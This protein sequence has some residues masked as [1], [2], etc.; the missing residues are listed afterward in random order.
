MSLS[1][2]IAVVMF[3][4][5]HIRVRWLHAHRDLSTFRG[6]VVHAG[7][8]SAPSEGNARRLAS[9]IHRERSRGGAMR[10]LARVADVDVD[11]NV[12]GDADD[13]PNPGG[14]VI[15]RASFGRVSRRARTLRRARAR[16]VRTKGILAFVRCVRDAYDVVLDD[17]GG[18]TIDRGDESGDAE[19]EASDTWVDRTMPA[20]VVPYAKLVRLD[21]PIGSALLAW[22][23]FWS[24]AL[25]ADRARCGRETA[26]VVRLGIFSPA[27]SG[28]HGERS[29]G[30]RPRW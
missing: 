12:D 10:A 16:F 22:P 18:E 8:P 13:V 20:S 7:A 30:S 5:D 23:C 25:A 6:A 19:P 14:S 4:I 29:V 11:R 15:V 27:W 28:M 3:L 9:W 17:R 1:F 21:R 24:I 26:C 2:D